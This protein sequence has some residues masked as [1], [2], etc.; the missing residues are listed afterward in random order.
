MNKTKNKI[1]L[2]A[3]TLMVVCLFSSCVYDSERACLFK[4]CT[5]D[6]LVIGA[7]RYA[8]ID[9]V[10]LQLC[11]DFSSPHTEAIA[12]WRGSDDIDIIEPDSIGVIDVDY[13]F[14]KTDTLYFFLVKYGNVKKY[15]LDEIRD[16]KLFGKCIVT[17][18][19]DGK[20]DRNIRYM[21]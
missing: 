10:C 19:V 20:F 17:R 11:S 15:S 5:G 8:E 18:D 21:E 4:N 1:H 9:S 7:S 6:T 3:C 14:A 12:F 13:L 2:L 16:K